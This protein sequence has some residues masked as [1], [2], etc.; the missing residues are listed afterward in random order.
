MAIRE[1]FSF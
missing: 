1:K